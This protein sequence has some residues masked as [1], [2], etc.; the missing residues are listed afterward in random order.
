MWTVSGLSD[1]N[2]GFHIQIVN[3]ANELVVVESSES[4]FA[5][6]NVNILSGLEGNANNCGVN[7]PLGE[8]VIGDGGNEFVLSRVKGSF[9][10]AVS[11][12]FYTH[13]HATYLVSESQGQ[14]CTPLHECHIL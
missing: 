14:F 11:I 1:G 9:T 13:E 6:E 12:D 7:E 2:K 8:Q 10:L 5:V 3:I 4:D